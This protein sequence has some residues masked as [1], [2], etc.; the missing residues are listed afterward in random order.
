MV[1]GPCE[2]YVFFRYSRLE[3]LSKYVSRNIHCIHIWLIPFVYSL[4]AFFSMRQEKKTLCVFSLTQLLYIDCSQDKSLLKFGIMK[5]FVYLTN[6]FTMKKTYNLSILQRTEQILGYKCNFYISWSLNLVSL[7]FISLYIDIFCDEFSDKCLVED[8]VSVTY[9][10]I[11][12]I[13][14]ISWLK[15]AIIYFLTLLWVDYL[16]QGS[17]EMAHVDCLW[18]LWDQ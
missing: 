16:G 15:T 17:A 13:L 3:N 18:Y 8:T 1:Y 5:T 2:S 14:K 6:K 11:S 9:C 4:I 10:C 12:D 7:S